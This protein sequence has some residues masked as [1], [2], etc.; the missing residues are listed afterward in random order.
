MRSAADD[1]SAGPFTQFTLGFGAPGFI[2]G[3]ESLP[4]AEPATVEPPVGDGS[5]AA[6]PPVQATSKTAINHIRFIGRA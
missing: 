2:V 1:V 3:I 6:L 4:V 5:L